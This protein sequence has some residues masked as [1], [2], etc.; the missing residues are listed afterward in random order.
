[1]RSQVELIEERQSRPDVGME[2]AAITPRGI[3][4][5]TRVGDVQEGRRN[6][7]KGKS[8]ASSCANLGFPLTTTNT[9]TN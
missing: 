4:R 9:T 1:M 3:T 8:S 7:P 5:K 2:V 6:K